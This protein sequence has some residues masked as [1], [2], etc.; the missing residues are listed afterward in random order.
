MREARVE[1]REELKQSDIKTIH[2][3]LDFSDRLVLGKPLY[4]ESLY[5]SVDL[6]LY[7]ESQ[8]K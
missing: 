2:R 5:I 3:K 1:I 4:W 8:L 6:V 7:M